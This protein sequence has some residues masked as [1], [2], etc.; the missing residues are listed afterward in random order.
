MKSTTNSTSAILVFPGQGSQ[1]VGMGQALYQSCPVARQVFDEA[2]EH[3]GLSVLHFNKE[4]FADTAN[5]QQALLVLEYACFRSLQSLLPDFQPAALAGHSLGEISALLCAE[6]LTFSDALELVRQ[7]GT[8]MQSTQKKGGMLAVID[9]DRALIDTVCNELASSHPECFIGISAYNSEQQLVLSGDEVMIVQAESKLKDLG[10]NAV[11]LS[12]PLAFHSP[13]MQEAADQFATVVN[14]MTIKTPRY[15]VISNVTA[16]PFSDGEEIK[17]LIVEQIAAPVRWQQSMSW[18]LAMGLPVIELGPKNTLSRLANKTKDNGTFIST[19]NPIA[20]RELILELLAPGKQHGGDENLTGAALQAYIERI[21]ASTRNSLQAKKEAHAAVKQCLSTIRNLD[22]SAEISDGEHE[23]I[24]RE[25]QYAL[26]HK[27]LSADKRKKLLAALDLKPKQEAI[28]LLCFSYAGGST[29]I[30][31]KWQALFNQ[32]FS[33]CPIKV[34]PVE[35]PGRGTKSKLPLETDVSSLVTSI[36]DEY[37][38]V[39]SG[40]Y[41]LFGH[42]LGGAVAYQ[43]TSYLKSQGRPSPTA[44]FVSG[45]PTPN[46]YKD[47]LL[48]SSVSDQEFLDNLRALNGIPDY[49]YQSDDLLNY[50][51]PILKSDVSLLSGWSTQPIADPDFP[52]VALGGDADTFAND[53]LIAEWGRFHQG[54][55]KHETLPGDHF[56][57]HE[58]GDVIQLIVSILNDCVA[59]TATHGPSSQQVG[60][61]VCE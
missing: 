9:A 58:P 57:I 44:V 43:L 45:C 17:R 27:D 18:L 52:L 32:V 40:R 4:H 61:P 16:E 47:N 15:P 60:E 8:I 30:Y 13:L 50:Y 12:N 53:S 19:D 42:S 22:F 59:T 54:R 14:G 28:K 55:F 25:F 29:Q 34:I 11:R 20:A 46:E 5:V 51:L 2:Q 10:C 39:F 48:L 38:D 31:A 23:R 24:Q 56:F 33:A 35:Y 26:E 36:Y 49:V 21:L 1:F 7:R 41:A 3:L 37:A 6:A